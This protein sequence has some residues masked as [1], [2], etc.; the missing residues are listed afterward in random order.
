MMVKIYLSN[1]HVMLPTN[2]SYVPLFLAYR[3][4]AMRVGH[5]E[6]NDLDDFVN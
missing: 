1:V 2:S 4:M 5:R 3:N 6:D